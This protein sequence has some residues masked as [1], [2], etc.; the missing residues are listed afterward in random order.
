MKGRDYRDFLNDILDA[1]TE[2]ESFIDDLSYDEFVKDRKTFNAVIRSIEVIGEATKNIPDE[3]K[4]E[5]KDLPWKRMAGMRDKLIHGYFGID[6]KTLYRAAEDD[7]PPLKALIQ[8]MQKEQE[9]RS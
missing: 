9:S 8:K 4:A 7:I 2:I 1:I 5:Y 3:I 6:S